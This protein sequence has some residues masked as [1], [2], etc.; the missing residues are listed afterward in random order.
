MITLSHVQQLAVEADGSTLLFGPAGTGKS[1]A[2]KQRLLKLLQEKNP[3][4][5]I[6]VLVAEPEHRQRYLDFVFEANVGP[7]ADLKVTN[8]VGLAR[9]MVSLFW[10]LVA[11]QAG[12]HNA[13]SSPTWLSYDL[14]QLLMWEVIDPMLA[15]GYFADLRLRPQQIVSQL[16]DN[17]NRSSLNRLTVGEAIQRQI[18]T[19]IGEEDRVRHLKDAERAAHSFRRICFEKNLLDLS[20]VIDVFNR[21]VVEH[22]QFSAYFSERFRHLLVDNIEEQTAAGQHFVSRMLNAT[23]STTIALD[24]GGGYK[25]FLAADPDLAV[26]FRQSCGRQLDFNER[27]VETQGVF[28]VARR[29]HRYLLGHGPEADDKLVADALLGTLETRYRREMMAELGGELLRLMEREKIAPRDIAIIVPYM[30]GALRY[31]L[32]QTLREAGIPYQLSRRRASPREEPRVR[33]WMTWLAL[34]HPDW[35]IFPTVYDVAEAFSL[36][37]DGFDPVRAALAAKMLY[38]PA[39]PELLSPDSLGPDQIERI[40]EGEL[41]RIGELRSWLLEHGSFGE[42]PLDLDFFIHHLFSDVLSQRNFST[43]ADVQAAAVCDWLVRLATRVKNAAGGLQL[44][45]PRQVGRAFVDGIRNGLVT[46]HPPDL[47]DPP[48]PNGVY[49]G[50]IYSFLLSEKVVAAQVWLETAASGWWDI[51]R[52]PLSNA[53]VLS[54]NWDPAQQWTLE[55]DARIRNEML[56]R[57]VSGLC[58]RCTRGVLLVTSELDRRGVRQDGPLWRGLQL[59]PQR[60]D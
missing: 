52:Q 30:D 5:T 47:G 1:T 36:S 41:L 54:E 50:T 18:E 59:M 48:D 24:D 34:A 21:F 44:E 35:E 49:I 6:L 40:G 25:R 38:Q 9:E 3:A 46:A 17:L 10:P 20:L 37:I 55:D 43:A 7:V 29:V 33:A 51:P 26:R 14:A 2:L 56:A 60:P 16:L 22:P 8:Y 27:F 42:E 15:N 11:R 58:A 57:I 4:Y 28:H 45:T 39:V 12:F 32:T 31:K 23:S 13:Y 19:W 53:F